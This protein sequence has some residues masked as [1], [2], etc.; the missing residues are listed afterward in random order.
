MGRSSPNK[1]KGQGSPRKRTACSGNSRLSGW[2]QVWAGGSGQTGKRSRKQFVKSQYALSYSDHIAS[3]WSCC[4]YLHFTEKETGIQWFVESFAR[5]QRI[6]RAR[7]STAPPDSEVHA[8][9]QY[10][11]PIREEKGILEVSGVDKRECKPIDDKEYLKYFQKGQDQS[12][13]QN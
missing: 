9:N 7:I 10:G 8:L 11:R 13:R 12:R 3:T 4:Y 5:S 6:G 2:P 1:E